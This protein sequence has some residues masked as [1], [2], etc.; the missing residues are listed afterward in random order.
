MHR[1]PHDL[2]TGV[3][4]LN[5]FLDLTGFVSLDLTGLPG[6]LSSVAR[7]RG[8][9]LVFYRDLNN[10]AAYISRFSLFLDLPAF[11]LNVRDHK[12]PGQLSSVARSR[13]LQLVFY[14][15]L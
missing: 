13:A 10:L 14:H 3:S 5:I 4:F 6:Q 1:N 2:A 9:Q 7:S 15:D 8:L 11:L 12:L